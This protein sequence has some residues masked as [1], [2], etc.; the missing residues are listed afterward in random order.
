MT[1][2]RPPMIKHPPTYNAYI[3]GLR[4]VAVLGV[5]AYH[6]DPTLLPGGF[7]G[8]DIFFVISGFLIT[9]LI[10]RDFQ[11]NTFSFLNFYARRFRRLAPALLFTSILCLTIGGLLLTPEDLHQLGGASIATIFSVSNFFFLS[12]S[13][14]FDTDA[15]TKPLLHTWSL[16]VEEQFY[17][18]WPASLVA[19]LSIRR[20][21][22]TPIIVFTVSLLSLGLAIYFSTL[23]AELTFFLLPFRIF[24]F[25]IG[26]GILWINCKEVEN[27]WFSEIIPGFGLLMIIFSMILTS[28]ETPHPS[29]ITLIPCLGTALIIYSDE[30]TTVNRA[31]SW[32]VF[33]G[34]GLIS[35]SL[36]LIHWPIIVF[37]QYINLSNSLNPVEGLLIFTTSLVTAT[38]IYIYVE[39]PFRRAKIVDTKTLKNVSLLTTITVL[40]FS[41]HMWIYDGWPWRLPEGI[42][43]AGSKFDRKVIYSRNNT[44]GRSEFSNDKKVNLLVIGDSHQADFFNAMDLNQNL[45][46]NLEIR[47]MRLDDLC[48]YLFSEDNAD[49][50]TIN[51]RTK[52]QCADEVIDFKSSKKPQTANFVVISTGWE[53]VGINNLPH[54]FKWFQANL[55]AE[56]VILGRTMEFESVPKVVA[57]FNKPSIQALERFLASNRLEETDRINKLVINASESLNLKYFGKDQWL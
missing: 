34:T 52:N 56:L 54:F 26:A 24:E 31:L 35:Y 36:Y 44:I 22:I 9:R 53:D 7:F 17:L 45:T 3:D 25:G 15:L 18:I 14:Y 42:K 39:T 38:A 40:L 57:S 43:D 51:Q 6:I 55:D 50:P 32:R 11:S 19:L 27:K 12:T 4:A 41:S 47:S 2:L 37:Y 33:V 46:P 8:V 21:S 30:K 49:E 13:G 1:P 20:K 5:V 29:W 10:R 28:S 48:F 23:Y 16:S